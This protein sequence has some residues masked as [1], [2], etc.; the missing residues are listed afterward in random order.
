MVDDEEKVIETLVKNLQGSLVLSILSLKSCGLTEN[1]VLTLLHAMKHMQSLKLL[2]ISE[3]SIGSDGTKELASHLKYGKNLIDFNIFG[4]NCQD[5]GII[6]IIKAVKNHPKIQNLNIGMNDVT[7]KSSHYIEDLFHHKE[8][9]REFHCSLNFL[10]RAVTKILK[11]VAFNHSLKTLDLSY[12]NATESSIP[13]L[14]QVLKKNA[15]LTDINFQGNQLPPVAG[16]KFKEIF[17]TRTTTNADKTQ[18][19]HKENETLLH[20]GLFHGNFIVAS[21][22]KV[23]ETSLVD[24][25][26]NSG[27]KEYPYEPE[28]LLP[29]YDTGVNKHSNCVVS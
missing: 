3:N 27:K 16:I 2:D 29:K 11:E 23:I 8:N 25:R 10:G 15:T 20:F 13:P 6:A 4:N 5:D 21:D 18:E 22:I 26:Q 9:L 7:N 1:N 28:R 19:K 12:N 17:R 24:N 14:L